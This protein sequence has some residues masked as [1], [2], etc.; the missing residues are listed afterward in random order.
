MLPGGGMQV[1]WKNLSR[2]N[3]QFVQLR[4][5]VIN[6]TGADFA[7][8]RYDF[9][10]TSD[11]GASILNFYDT[12]IRY[13][14]DRADYPAAFNKRTDSD[15]NFVPPSVGSVVNLKGFIVLQPFSDQIGGSVPGSGVLS[16]LPFEDRGCND[17]GMDCDA[18]W[19]LFSLLHILRALLWTV[20][21]KFNKAR[22][23][24]WKSSR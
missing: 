15:G 10:V 9:H 2:L 17:P 20:L 6:A 22:H 13:R 4:S 14:N 18:I 11:D 16:I 19:R 8:G 12:S 21:P 24:V 5:V 1:N 23:H 3:G 7:P